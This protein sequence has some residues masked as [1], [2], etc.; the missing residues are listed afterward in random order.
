[1]LASAYAMKRMYPRALAEYDKIADE[2]KTVAA[3]NQFVDGGL[4]WIYAGLRQAQ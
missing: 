2:D 4:G 1:M 3:E